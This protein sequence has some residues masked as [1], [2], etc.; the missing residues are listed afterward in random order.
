MQLASPAQLKLSRI[1]LGTG[2]YSSYR[3]TP[4][5]NS[6]DAAKNDFY[7]E[8][9]RLLNM[10]QLSDI[11]LVAGEL[12]TS[13]QGLGGP[14]VLAFKSTDN[15]DRLLHLC[16]THGLFLANTNFR[17]RKIHRAT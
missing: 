15:G 13:E 1:D 14:F 17:H 3:C 5:Q 10:R 8:L 6:S 2:L 12:S 9:N 4:Q 7:D 11:V 16:S